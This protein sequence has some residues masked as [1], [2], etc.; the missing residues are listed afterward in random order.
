QAGGL[1]ADD[2]RAR[3]REKA[4]RLPRCC[5]ATWPGVDRVATRAPS[6]TWTRAA[7]DRMRDRDRAPMREVACDLRAHPFPIRHALRTRR[8]PARQPPSAN[9]GF[10][11]RAIFRAHPAPVG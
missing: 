4:H 6:P 9:T 7:C 2:R 1:L 5:G 11:S 8:Q 10:V 3:A